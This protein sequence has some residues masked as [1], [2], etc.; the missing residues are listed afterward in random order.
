MA[1]DGSASA[2]RKNLLMAAGFVI[3]MAG[4]FFYWRSSGGAPPGSSRQAF[5]TTDDGRTWFKD[6]MKKLPPF[7]RDGK[8]AYRCYLHTSDGGKTTQVTYLERYTADAKKVMEQLQASGGR[9]DMA[10][11]Q[12]LMK[13]IEVKPAGAPESEWIN[14][15]DPRAAGVMFSQGLGGEG[16]EILPVEP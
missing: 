9:P 15:A 3:L 1:S 12:I 10:S 6:D 2:N 16:R 5:F 8:P 11:E 14:K 4:A 7:D 13:G